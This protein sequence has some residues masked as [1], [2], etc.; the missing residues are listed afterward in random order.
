[1]YHWRKLLLTD[2]KHRA[3]SLRQQSYLLSNGIKFGE[4]IERSFQ[5]LN[6]ISSLHFGKQAHDGSVWNSQFQPITS[7]IWRHFKK[8]AY[9]ACT[10]LAWKGRALKRERFVTDFCYC[11]KD[12][13]IRRRAHILK[14]NMV[15]RAIA[16]SDNKDTLYAN[17]TR[18][19]KKGAIVFWLLLWQI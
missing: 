19:R 12:V 18:F 8:S 15:I 6:K 5:I 11:Y 13:N 16:W 9:S 4:N 7:L 2:T 14:N 10:G 1:M 3:A 17:L